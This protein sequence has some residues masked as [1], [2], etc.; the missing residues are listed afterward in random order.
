[1]TSTETVMCVWCQ[2]R[3]DNFHTIM[4]MELHP[5]TSEHWGFS[6]CFW[7]WWVGFVFPNVFQKQTH[8]F[9]WNSI[10]L[11]E[12]ELSDL[13]KTEQKRYFMSG[14]KFLVKTTKKQTP[15]LSEKGSLRIHLIHYQPDSR[16]TFNSP[17][18]SSYCP[19]RD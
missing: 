9:F 15:F 18:D 16:R 2:S 12:D 19:T 10:D 3:H 1:M 5:Q 4:S 7:W 17:G 11:S 6:S 8:K 14:I 13:A